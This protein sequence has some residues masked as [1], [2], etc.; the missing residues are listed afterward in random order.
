MGM[1]QI[2]AP[3]ATAHEVDGSS[4]LFQFHFKGSHEGI[5]SH[6]GYAVASAVDLDADGEFIIGHGDVLL[7]A[8]DIRGPKF[9]VRNVQLSTAELRYLILIPDI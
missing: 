3:V 6:H 2:T 1:A 5:F 7:V 8:S 4:R 9:D